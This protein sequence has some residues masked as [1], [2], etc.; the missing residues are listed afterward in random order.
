MN[1][2]AAL[3]TL[4][5]FVLLAGCGSP[6]GGSPD[7]G[8]M[9]AAFPDVGVSAYPLPPVNAG[10]DYQLGEAYAP[11]AGVGI[12]ARDR[13]A[14][15]APGL[16]NLCY[17]N[18][19][20]VQPHEESF[21]LTEHPELVLRDDQGD[22]VVDAAWDEMLL[23]TSTA[24]KRGAIA[25]I[26]G[27]WI[28]GCATAGFD[29]VEIDNL[30]SFSRSGER[31]TEEHAVAMMRLFADAAHA[32]GLAISQKNAA[33]LV[34]RRAEMGTDFVVAEE[35]NRYRECG[36]YTAGYGAHVLVIEYR[37]QDFT[38]GCADFPG[39]S[40]VLRDRNLVGPAAGAYVHDGC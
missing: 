12:V 32:E 22:P 8:S 36:V 14:S 23:D 37:R 25:G 33:D 4:A 6:S 26:V 19:F 17:V 5:L 2:R 29:A 24:E 21:W 27:G 20:Q 16:F 34:G 38:R 18:G 35:C 39:L 13:E 30:D 3:S 7:G 11:P 1:P 10:L 9:D 15:V 28:A 31:L 40:I